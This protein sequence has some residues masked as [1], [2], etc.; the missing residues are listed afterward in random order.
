[1]PAFR[2]SMAETA[3]LGQAAPR[4]LD[5]AGNGLQNDIVDTLAGHKLESAITILL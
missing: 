5:S 1:M 2:I 3:E 4:L